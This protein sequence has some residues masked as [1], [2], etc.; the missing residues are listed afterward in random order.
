MHTKKTVR[1]EAATN[2]W[3]NHETHELHLRE[4]A[5]SAS[6]DSLRQTA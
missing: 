1:R 3:L 2:D 6:D 4:S 5:E